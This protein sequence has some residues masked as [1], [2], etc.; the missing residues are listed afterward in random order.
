MAPPAIQLEQLLGDGFLE[1]LQSLRISARRVPRRGR[2][3][4]QRSKDLGSG[5]EFRDFRPYVPGDDLRSIDWNIYRRLGRVFLRLFEEMEDLP[6]YLMPDVSRSMYFEAPPRALGG[7][8]CAL[9][10]AA[11]SVDSRVRRSASA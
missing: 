1:A 5:I 4:E 3:A 2:H 7:L 6:L 10:L 8:R 9:A 11:V